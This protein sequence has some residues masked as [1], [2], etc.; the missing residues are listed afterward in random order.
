MI[1][2]ARAQ[3]KYSAAYTWVRLVNEGTKR[4]K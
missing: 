3:L 2:D 1:A 4:K